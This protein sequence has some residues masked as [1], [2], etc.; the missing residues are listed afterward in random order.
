M[1]LFDDK[2]RLDRVFLFLSDKKGEKMHRMK[3]IYFLEK[4]SFDC[5]VVFQ[6]VCVIFECVFCLFVSFALPEEKKAFTFKNI[7]LRQRKTSKNKD[8][9]ILSP[10]VAWKRQVKIGV[11]TISIKCHLKKDNVCFY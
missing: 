9:S 5:L 3:T 7:L 10:F 6:S 1:V 4:N 11:K 8:K 2:T